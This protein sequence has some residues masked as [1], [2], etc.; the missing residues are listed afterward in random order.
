MCIALGS[1][2]QV[3]IFELQTPPVVAGNTYNVH[4]IGYQNYEGYGN[5]YSSSFAIEFA[6]SLSYNYYSGLYMNGGNFTYN[7]SPSGS[8]PGKIK[9]SLRMREN[10]DIHGTTKTELW[11]TYLEL[12]AIGS[13]TI[14]L[15]SNTFSKSINIGSMNTNAGIPVAISISGSTE[16]TGSWGHYGDFSSSR[17]ALSTNEQVDLFTLASAQSN[18]NNYDIAYFGY[19]S[20]PSYGNSYEDIFA[21]EYADSVSYNYS[22]GFYINGGNTNLNLTVSGSP[23]ISSTMRMRDNGD[24]TATTTIFGGTVDVSAIGNGTL[25]LGDN[26][27]TS[28]INL[29]GSGTS[30]T[31]SGSI[32]HLGDYTISGKVEQTFGAPATNNQ[33]DLLTITGSTDNDSRAYNV[34]TVGIQ[35][36]PSYGAT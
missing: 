10:N 19:Q 15:G 7:L 9:S 3:D 28:Q 16:S 24:G 14:D 11:G 31:I 35:D 34:F 21:I 25:K 17:D 8:V 12:N 26:G 5:Q 23:S 36:Y 4:T 13:G 18:G 1:N 20:Y 27:F 33:I 29:G 2:T 22:N 30:T 32:S 6:D